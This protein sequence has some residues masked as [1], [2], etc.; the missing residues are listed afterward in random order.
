MLTRTSWGHGWLVGLVGIIVAA[1]GFW[2]ARRSRSGAGWAIAALGAVAIVI[3]PALTG[4]AISTSPVPLSVALD[5]LHVG[6]VCAWLGSLLALLFS[7]VP[8]VRGAR[9]RSSLGS[10]PLVAALVRSFHP[11]ALTC[12]AIVVVTGIVAAWLRLPALSDL[13]ASTYGRVLLLK[14]CFVALVIVMGAVNWRRIM[15]ALGDEASARRLTRTA[16]AELTMAA[17][18]L[19]VTSVLVSIS[20]P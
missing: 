4:H 18:V 13:W 11:I 5:I 10:G 6:A 9:A 15:P 12:A 1:V 16:G 8:F 19:A 17:L 2:T 14:L 7:A 3:A 20:P